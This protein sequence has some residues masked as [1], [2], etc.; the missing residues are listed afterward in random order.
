MASTC[1]MFIRFAVI[2]SCAMVSLSSRADTNVAA[3]LLALPA[4]ALPATER[5]A[6]EPQNAS[7]NQALAELAKEVLLKSIKPEYDKQENWGHQKEM[8]DGYHWAQHPD[9][10]H[11]EKQT[12]KVNDG[13]WRVIQ[14]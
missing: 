1:N 13:L 14:T 12:R 7:P 10:W 5:P 4:P 8:V 9:G 2:M 6:T 3:P 11:L